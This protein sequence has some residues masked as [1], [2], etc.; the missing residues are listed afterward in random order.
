MDVASIINAARKFNVHLDMVNHQ[1]ILHMIIKLKQNMANHGLSHLVLLCSFP[2]DY[3]FFVFCYCC[4]L[5]SNVLLDP[6]YKH[7]KIKEKKK[8]Y[9]HL[10][11]N[12]GLL[13]L[14]PLLLLLM[15]INKY[16]RFLIQV[17]N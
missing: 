4:I 11:P 17:E 14:S 15:I 8:K 1:Y 7:Y 2:W 12:K 5:S 10:I 3:L 13:H 6:I 9:L 16:N